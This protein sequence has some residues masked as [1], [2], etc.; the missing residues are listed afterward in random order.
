[1]PQMLVIHACDF[2]SREVL[3]VREGQR[4]RLSASGT[5]HDLAYACNADG[6]ESPNAYMRFF[7]HWRRV[8]AARWFALIGALDRDAET[9]VVLGREHIYVPPR[10][11]ELSFF[12]NDVPGMYWNNW[13]TLVLAVEFLGSG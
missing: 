11:G 7:E 9:L 13:G 3:P 4:Y 5:W 8:P 10:D 1:M 2:W 6:Y 12:A